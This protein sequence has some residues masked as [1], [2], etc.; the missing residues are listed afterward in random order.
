MTKLFQ[1][2]GMVIYD[3]KEKNRV[4]ETHI[5]DISPRAYAKHGGPW[6]VSCKHQIIPVLEKHKTVSCKT[7]GFRGFGYGV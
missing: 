2:I 7:D 1:S 5:D 6:A 3:Q 4:N